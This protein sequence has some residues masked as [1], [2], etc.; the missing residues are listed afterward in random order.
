MLRARIHT[1]TLTIHAI[2]PTCKHTY[3]YTYTHTSTKHSLGGVRQGVGGPSRAYRRRWA[4]LRPWASARGRAPWGAECPCIAR[5][6]ARPR[7]EALR[8]EETRGQDTT[9]E[10]ERGTWKAVVVRVLGM[11]KGRKGGGAFKSRC[12]RFHGV[13]M[14]AVIERGWG[15]GKCGGAGGGLYVMVGVVDESMAEKHECQKK[16]GDTLLIILNIIYCIYYLYTLL[17]TLSARSSH[18]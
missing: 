3:D 18:T 6:C 4:Q 16:A 2:H 11:R 12:E 17:Y 14:E 13:A 1:L 9:S 7:E 15:M 5:S 10:E 8:K